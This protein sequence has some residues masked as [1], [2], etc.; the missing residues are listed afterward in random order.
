VRDDERWFTGPL[1]LG[2]GHLRL[3]DE[4]DVV[5][6]GGR[7]GLGYLR[8]R[9]RIDPDDWYFACHFHRDPVMPGSLGV[10]AVLQALQV[11][12]LDAGLAD[13]FARPEFAL[14]R[15]V[16]MGWKYRGQI[17]RTD[18]EMTFDLHVKEIRR[19]DGELLVIADASIWRRPTSDAPRRGPGLRIYELTDVAVAV[20]DHDHQ[21]EAR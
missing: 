21:E 5:D 17:L 2:D 3:V 16:P 20:R 12:V 18:R 14:P 10:E 8:G 13:G 7:H 1:R 11:F 9:R 15:D 6:G 4:V 19:A